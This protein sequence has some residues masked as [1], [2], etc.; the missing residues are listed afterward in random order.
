MIEQW[1]RMKRIQTPNN[2]WNVLEMSCIGFRRFSFFDDF[3]ICFL[4]FF[5]LVFGFDTYNCSSNCWIMT[6]ILR[7]PSGSLFIMRCCRLMLSKIF[8]LEDKQWISIGSVIL[9]WRL[10]LSVACD[11]GWVDFSAILWVGRISWD[12]TK[13]ISKVTDGGVIY[14]F[15]T[16]DQRY[17]ATRFFEWNI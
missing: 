6:K 10:L 9:N 4:P 12:L 1:A 11:V 3:F 8:S 13:V 17:R 14:S 5:W 7:P 2:S 15:P 16:Q